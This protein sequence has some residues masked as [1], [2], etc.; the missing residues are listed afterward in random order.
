M[1]LKTV[2]PKHDYVSFTDNVSVPQTMD[3]SVNPGF[4]EL[5][6]STP[7]TVFHASRLVALVG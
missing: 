3:Y 7:G 2:I 5:V 6:S 1:G 4:A